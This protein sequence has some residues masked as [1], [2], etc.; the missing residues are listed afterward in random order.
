LFLLVKQIDELGKQW[1]LN[2]EI[3]AVE[4][5]VKSDVVIARGVALPAESSPRLEGQR[6]AGDRDSL[7]AATP[8]SAA[9][10]ERPPPA[11]E[12]AAPVPGLAASPPRSSSPLAAACSTPDCLLSSSVSGLDSVI[13]QLM[14][15]HRDDDVTK[16]ADRTC[17]RRAVII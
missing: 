14:T 5:E 7:P 9:V 6:S 12:T 13:Q 4:P 1:R 3:V 15:S 17:Y 10:T 8:S 16:N 2:D 11:A